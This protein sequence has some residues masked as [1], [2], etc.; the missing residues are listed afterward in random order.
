MNKQLTMRPG[1]VLNLMT[2]FAVALV[3]VTIICGFRTFKW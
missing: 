3:F 2:V 1:F